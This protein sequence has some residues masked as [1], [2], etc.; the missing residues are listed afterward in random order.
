MRGKKQHKLEDTPGGISCTP[1]GG[2]PG[3]NELINGLSEV[4]A[5]TS[6]GMLEGSDGLG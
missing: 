4:W 3:N 6:G 1:C 5:S 2:G